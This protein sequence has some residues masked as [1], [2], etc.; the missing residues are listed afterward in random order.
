MLQ[1]I[2][3]LDTDLIDHLTPKL[4]QPRP[5][6]YTFTKAI[7][8]S[9]IKTECID[10][11]CCIVR[12]SIIGASRSEPFPGWV[13]NFYGP[14]MLFAAIGTGLFRCMMGD[15]DAICDTVPVDSTVNCLIAASWSVGT[16]QFESQNV[17]VYNCTSGQIN[18]VKWGTLKNYCLSSINIYPFENIFLT[19]GFTL[20]KYKCICNVKTFFLQTMPAYVADFFLRLFLRKPT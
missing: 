7:A 13:D 6:T 2:D 17:I 9:L 5:N 16:K 19:P 14:S 8:E 12:P 1:T 11:P 18:K 10:M 4:I 20:S 3:L 15:D